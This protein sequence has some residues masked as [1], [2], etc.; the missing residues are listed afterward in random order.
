MFGLR[1]NLI[2]TLYFY[3]YSPNHYL[4]MYPNIDPNLY[5]K[6]CTRL[7]KFCT[8]LSKFQQNGEQNG[9]QTITSTQEYTVS[10]D[11]L[12]ANFQLTYIPHQIRCKSFMHNFNLLLD[13]IINNNFLNTE[14]PTISENEVVYENT[15]NVHNIF[16]ESSVG[17]SIANIIK[18]NYVVNH[19]E[20]VASILE[21]NL[22]NKSLVFEFFEDS[23]KINEVDYKTLFCFVWNRIQ[24]HE[25]KNNIITILD[26]ELDDSKDKCLTGKISRLVNCL[27]GFYDDVNIEISVNDQLS[28][29]VC[30]IKKKLLV[31][32]DDE[33]YDNLLKEKISVE[34]KER[35]YDD[36]TV[37]SWTS[38]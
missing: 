13:D 4:S 2:F 10:N 36:S 14:I 9:K 38:F 27:V 26:N 22:I 23:K 21:S 11:L 24:K 19:N 33:S 16:I 3:K 15:Q 25:C 6:F 20:T 28:S 7:S 12:L 30:Q 8:R 18:D 29:I 35:G 31:S 5:K 17:K 1:K 34:L 37:E 32:Q